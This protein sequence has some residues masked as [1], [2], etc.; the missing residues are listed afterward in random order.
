MNTPMKVPESQMRP[1]IW[2]AAYAVACI[3]A[4]QAPLR[5]LMKLALAS[6]PYSHILIVPAVSIFLLWMERKRVFQ[7]LG[8]N[9]SAAVI[10][11]FAGALLAVFGKSAA[12]LPACENWL[13]L[14]VL[15]FLCLI[16]AGF[17]F[18][19]GTQAFK[20][21]LFSLL[22]LL[23]MV[24]LP[25]FLLDRFITWLQA[26]SADVAE[27]IFHLSGIPILRR[28]MIFVLPQVSIEVAKECS[29]IRST[30]ALLITCL[31][32]GHLFLRTNWR[33]TVL[34]AAAVPV[35]VIK[36]GVRIATLTLLAVRVDPSFL[37]G[38]LHHQGGFV[39]FALAM[40]FLLPLLWW[41]QKM[42][43]SPPLDHT[44]P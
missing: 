18:F 15:G 22:F 32:A 3:A 14:T 24:P 34:L 7:T 31:L 4:F 13:G 1:T 44:A 6:D 11:F 37:T 9:R 28:G 2:F 23:L 20:A 30:E 19:Y 36:N 26:G 5:A 16:W 10:L 39:F 12:S 40:L 41:L 17:L 25:E 29:G 8:C 42:E 33:R 27:W 21:G 35:L 43:A 38:R